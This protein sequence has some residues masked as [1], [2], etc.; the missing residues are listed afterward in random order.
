MPQY[1]L[2]AKNIVIS[3]NEKLILYENLISCTRIAFLLS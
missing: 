3:L 1:R 2:F